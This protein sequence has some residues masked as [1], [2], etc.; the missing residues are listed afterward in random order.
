MAGFYEGKFKEFLER[1]KKLKNPLAANT[2]NPV[3]PG[4]GGEAETRSI[5]ALNSL[6]NRL[7]GR[8]QRR[9]GMG[10]F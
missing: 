6:R 9:P 2:V 4:A 5:Y 10:Q 3:G 1:R 8:L 7:I